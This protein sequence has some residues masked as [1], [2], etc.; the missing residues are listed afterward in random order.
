M[1]LFLKLKGRLAIAKSAY[2]NLKTVL[3]HEGRTFCW[4]TFSKASR[5]GFTIWLIGL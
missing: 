4:A 3:E 1:N 2:Y 5:D